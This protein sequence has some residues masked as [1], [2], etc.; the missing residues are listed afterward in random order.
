MKNFKTLVSV[1]LFLFTV[2]GLISCKK[3]DE[4]PGISLRSKSARVENQWK[5]SFA[6]YL[7]DGTVTTEDHIGDI[8]EFTKDGVF[9]KDGNPKGMWELSESKEQIIITEHDGSIDFFNIL[10]LK[11]NEMWLSE[12]GDEELHLTTL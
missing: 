8:W 3:Y 7:S 12:P 2:I 10:K 5:I 11:E 6:R 1:T 4:G 9:V